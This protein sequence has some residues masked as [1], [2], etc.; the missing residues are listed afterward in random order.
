VDALSC[1]P[2]TLAYD[3]DNFVNEI[4]DMHMF[5]KMGIQTWI[6]RRGF[7]HQEIIASKLEIA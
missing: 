1:N 3:D 2:A 5:R 7:R 4:Q 6:G